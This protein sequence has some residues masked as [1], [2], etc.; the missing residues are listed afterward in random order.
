MRLSELLI[1]GKQGTWSI[2]IRE[3]KI[4]S[5]TASASSEPHLSFNGAL[6]FPG[7]IN[8][9]EHLDFNLFPQLGNRV[10]TN[11]RD[12]G[13]DIHAN[14]KAEIQAVLK[15]PLPLRIQWGI[16][17]NLLNGFTTVVNHGSRLSIINSPITVHQDCYNIHSVGFGSHWKWELNHPFKRSSP[18]VF[19]VGEGTDDLAR[20]EISRLLRWNL[21]KRSLIGVH[22]VAMT[23]EQ[24]KGF[25]ALVWCPASNYFLLDRTAPISRLKEKTSILFGTDSTLTAPWDAWCQI[26]LARQEGAATDEE[27]F[28]M[29][30]TAPAAAWGLA[31]RGNLEAGKKADLVISRPVSTNNPAG[32]NNPA[33]GLNHWDSFYSTTPSDILLVLSGGNIVLFDPSLKPLL[34]KAGLLHGEFHPAGPGG[35]YIPC[36]LMGLMDGIRSYYPAVPF[37][38]LPGP[39]AITGPLLHGS[40]KSNLTE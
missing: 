19:H 14:N 12:W 39:A 11:Y 16:Y 34:E 33:A 22:G 29:L 6:A 27:L 15:I 40:I 13:P 36:D 38:R 23:E 26:R 25:R 10:Y 21:F 4:M 32:T 31:D 3:G 5:V 1:P 37:P 18:F 2:D 17:K 9:H 30:T 8:S 24:A 7:L 28:D 20:T 35:K